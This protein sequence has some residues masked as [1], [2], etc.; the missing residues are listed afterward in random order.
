MRTKGALTKKLIWDLEIKQ[1]DNVIHA[2]R[3]PCLRTAADS[4]GLRYDQLSE[5]RKGRT[6]NFTKYKFAPTIAIR[7]IEEMEPEKENAANL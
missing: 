2:G 1:G 5:L 7:K 6:K 3:Y 4:C